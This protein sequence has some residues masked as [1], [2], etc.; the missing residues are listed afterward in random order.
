MAD[1][2][3][4]SSGSDSPPDHAETVAANDDGDGEIG[5][6]G[7]FLSDYVVY[8]GAT[9]PDPRTGSIGEVADALC[10]IIGAEGTII[11]T[12]AYTIYLRGCGIKRLAG[13]LKDTMNKALASAVGQ[14]RVISENVTSRTGLLLSTVRTKGTPAVR[15][16]RRGPRTFEEIPPSELRAV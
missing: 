11:A 6:A 16:R 9:G 8:S 2:D 14:G 5:E 10:Q 7:V 4:D 3:V 13:G 15:P 1:M 12:R